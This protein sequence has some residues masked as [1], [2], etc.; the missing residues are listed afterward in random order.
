MNL[1]SMPLVKLLL[2]HILEFIHHLYFDLDTFSQIRGGDVLLGSCDVHV[3]EDVVDVFLFGRLLL[4]HILVL[5]FYQVIFKYW[6]I[7]SG[8]LYNFT[9]QFRYLCVYF[10]HILSASFIFLRSIQPFRLFNDFTLLYLAEFRLRHSLHVFVKLLP[11]LLGISTFLIDK[12][13]HHLY[14]F[15][16]LVDV[17]FLFVFD[18]I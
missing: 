14:L 5:Q 7:L 3:S 8:I 4:L 11:Y 18:S 15:L 13:S 16:S 12:S 2:S 10:P 9:R 17:S 6:L 1:N